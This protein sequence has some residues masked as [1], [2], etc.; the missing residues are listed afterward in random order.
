MNPMENNKI[1]AEEG[2]MPEMENQSRQFRPLD[3]LVRRRWQLLACLLLVCGIAF[4]AATLRQDSYEATV[5]LSISD[6]QSSVPGIM[7][8]GGGGGNQHIKTQCELLESRNVL[9]QAIERLQLAGNQWAYNDEAINALKSQLYV[10]QIAGTN[11]VD[12]TGSAPNPAQAAAIAN[13]VAAAFISQTSEAKKVATDRAINQINR[14]VAGYEKEIAEYTEEIRRIRQENLITSTNS[15]VR[16]TEG[17][18][19]AIESELT[20][21]QLQ[22]LALE[23]E[24]EVY[25][26]QLTTDKSVALVGSVS[27]TVNSLNNELSRLKQDETQM[28]RV[29]LPGH[30]KLKNIRN[31]I[32]DLEMRIEQEKRKALGEQYEQSLN[33]YAVKIK[34]EDAL[35]DLLNEQRVI[36]VQ[37]SLSSEEYVQLTANLEAAQR[38]KQESTLR[39]RQYSLEKNMAEPPVEVVDVALPPNSPAGL[40]RN[41]QAAAILLLGIVFSIAFIFIVDRCAMPSNNVNPMMQ[42]MPMM[43][44]PMPVNAAWPGTQSPQTQAAQYPEP[45]PQ[46]QTNH[47]VFT[48][49][50]D[51]SDWAAMPK[52]KLCAID[53]NAANTQNMSFAQRCRM[54]HT[55]QAS[56]QAAA[57]RDLSM[58]LLTR[59]DVI[60]PTLSITSITRGS[61]STTVACNL[62]LAL[63]QAGR[64]VLLIDANIQNP[65]I[66]GVFADLYAEPGLTDVLADID[67]LTETIQETDIP[68]L[69]IMTC[70][71]RQITDSAPEALPNLNDILASQFDWVI[72]DSSSMEVSFTNA[73]LEAVDNAVLVTGNPAAAV[74]GMEHIT[75]CRTNAL[76]YVHNTSVNAKSGFRDVVTNNHST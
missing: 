27:G 47:P 26:Q 8:L 28:S 32:E 68:N 13:H 76:G 75:S 45:A 23:G 18:I 52:G 57:F 67:L 15:M 59:N 49:E 33:V 6:E 58:H 50:Q 4:S 24:T 60:K 31:R 46:A 14:Q 25:G 72:Y 10:R 69:T 39:L 34:H 70:G 22:R 12:I 74:T 29:Y 36:G 20:R 3:V 66:E 11:L 55:N 38:M 17:R 56:A 5:R 41:K 64:S 54:V 21:T 43:Y 16:A 35:R 37:Q 51:D 30:E 73:I 2:N 63:A 61:G 7:A 71:N 53:L 44:M 65:A 42:G 48:P 19:A 9:A 1:A 40:D 62:A